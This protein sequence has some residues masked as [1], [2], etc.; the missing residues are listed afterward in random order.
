MFCFSFLF[1]NFHLARGLFSF[2]SF[3][4]ARRYS[5]DVIATSTKREIASIW[6]LDY[7]TNSF[8]ESKMCVS[9]TR[10][11]SRNMFVASEHLMSHTTGEMLMKFHEM[12]SI[13][14]IRNKM[15]ML[16]HSLNDMFQREF[17]QFQALLRFCH[18]EVK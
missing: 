8:R 17:S 9:F 2:L 5:T 15:Q 3:L 10:F 14:A 7:S 11:L 6:H 13:S 1:L 4:K 18:S 12:P 16:S